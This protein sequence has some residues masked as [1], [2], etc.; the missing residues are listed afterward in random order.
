MKGNLGLKGF[1]VSPKANIMLFKAYDRVVDLS[2][3]FLQLFVVCLYKVE[4][5]SCG[6]SGQYAPHCLINYTHVASHKKVITL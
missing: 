4:P 3:L 1:L 5:F 6:C 2:R